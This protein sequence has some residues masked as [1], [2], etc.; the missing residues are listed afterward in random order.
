MTH[1][2]SSEMALNL[3]GHTDY[4]WNKLKLESRQI[5]LFPLCF[6]IID[7]EL[8][9]PLLSHPLPP[10]PAIGPGRLNSKDTSTSFFA[11]GLGLGLAYGKVWSM[12]NTNRRLILYKGK[13][14]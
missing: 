4:Y 3:T 7:G 6:S 14:V 2:R 10:L 11:V 12:S 8:P 9:L 1:S 5:I 13:R